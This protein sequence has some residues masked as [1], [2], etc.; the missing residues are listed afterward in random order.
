MTPS[1]KAVKMA[2]YFNVVKIDSSFNVIK[3]SHLSM[4]LELTHLTY[5]VVK[6]SH[7]SLWL[8]LPHLLMWLICSYC[9]VVKMAWLEWAHHANGV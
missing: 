2:S 4:W 7:I 6:W 3:W 8:K 9:N 5:H 1:F